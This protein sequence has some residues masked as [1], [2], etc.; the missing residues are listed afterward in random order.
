[1]DEIFSLGKSATTA[2]DGVTTTLAS[3]PFMPILSSVPGTR[4]STSSQKTYLL[5][6]TSLEFVAEEY[7]SDQEECYP[8]EN[9]P[10]PV[11]GSSVISVLIT[12][13]D[14]G[15]SPSALLNSRLSRM[16]G[17]RKW[18]NHTIAQFSTIKPRL[19]SLFVADDKS[20]LQEASCMRC[21]EVFHF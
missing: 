20:Y 6:H 10:T 3:V 15:R 1:V 7:S 12:L 21:S 14:K 16:R 18:N 5:F 4:E 9:T 13:D 8:L 19:A 2:D 17:I 11:S